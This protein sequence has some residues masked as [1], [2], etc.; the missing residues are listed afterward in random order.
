MAADLSQGRRAL[1]MALVLFGPQPTVIVSNEG[2]GGWRHGN[3]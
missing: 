1:I 3:K 2:Q